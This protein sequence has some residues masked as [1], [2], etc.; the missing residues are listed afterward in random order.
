MRRRDGAVELA[1]RLVPELRRSVRLIRLREPDPTDEDAAEMRLDNAS[2][3]AIAAMER[4]ALAAVAL[5]GPDAGGPASDLAC[6]AA[7][8]RAAFEAKPLDAL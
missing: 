2:P 7:T 1:Q 4:L 8:L 3:R 5:N 6:V